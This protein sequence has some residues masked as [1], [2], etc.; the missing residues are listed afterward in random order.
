M[1][2]VMDAVRSHIC[3]SVT[4]CP[5]NYEPTAATCMQIYIKLS[6]YNAMEMNT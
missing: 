5:L 4:R 3:I 1:E 2:G 6:Y